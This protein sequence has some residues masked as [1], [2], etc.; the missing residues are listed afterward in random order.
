MDAA[1]KN[2]QTL[3][4]AIRSRPGVYRCNPCRRTPDLGK[5]NISCSR[6]QHPEIC[7]WLDENLVA[8]WESLP[9]S[10]LLALKPFNSP[11]RLAKGRLASSG[12][13][14]NSGLTDA[15]PVEDCFRTLEANLPL[16]NTPST[17]YHNAW[18]KA[19][20]VN[21]IA[22]SFNVQEFPKM[23]E[24]DKT[25]KSMATIAQENTS[26][27]TGNTGSIVTESIINTSVSAITESLVTE[28][29]K[30]R[31]SAYQQSRKIEDDAFTARIQ[32]LEQKHL[33]RLSCA[34]HRNL[35]PMGAELGTKIQ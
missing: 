20:P 5:W 35:V 31:I 8:L 17:V 24:S 28:T 3:W 25:H 4:T 2:G 18:D 16:T 34:M 9:K 11:E 27:A 22:Y 29:I 23:S 1:T 13:S 19:L 12:S 33:E 15:S 30:T 21:D 10:S 7:E 6:T 14:V 26:Q 32:D